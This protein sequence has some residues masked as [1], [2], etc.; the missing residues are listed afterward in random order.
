MESAELEVLIGELEQRVERLRSLYEQYFMGIEKIEP[1]VLRKDVERRFWLLRREQIRNTALRFKLNMVIQRYNTFQQYWQRICREIENGT[2][3]RD[4]QRAATR[5]GTD[6]LLTITARKRFGKLLARTAEAASN[7]DSEGGEVGSEDDVVELSADEFEEAQSERFGA[8]TAAAGVVTASDDEDYLGFFAQAVVG[9]RETPSHP[10]VASPVPAARP[11]ARPATST[12]QERPAGTQSDRP[13]EFATLLKPARQPSRPPQ[14]RQPSH[15]SPTVRSEAPGAS[16]SRSPRGAPE[17]AHASS[18]QV[19]PAEPPRPS[20]QPSA[21]A[22]QGGVRH[23]SRQLGGDSD[24]SRLHQPRSGHPPRTS[25]RPEPAKPRTD[26]DPT[27]NDQTV[28]AKARSDDLD[29][30]DARVRQIY[31]KY[32][33]A[34]RDCR[35]STSTVTVSSLA[36]TL[37]SSA[38]KLK[39]KHEGRAVDFEVVIKNGKA[40]LKPVL[41]G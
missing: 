22:S 18:Q 3:K 19:P 11:S 35:E 7:T 6:A 1:S 24:G 16:P 14:V 4:V 12:Q 26:S 9:V 15:P 30:S 39:A 38:E 17:R 10:P 28:T 20:S 27:R 29:I 40:V 32:V 31:E 34:K 2:Y 13:Q 37:R 25:G 21:Q 41:K 8:Q 5:F 36:K 33:Q 23:G